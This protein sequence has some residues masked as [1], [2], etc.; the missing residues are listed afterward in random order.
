MVRDT[1]MTLGIL[2]FGRRLMSVLAL[3]AVAACAGPSWDGKVYHG[4]SV[5]F[6]VGRV[7]PG[8]RKLEDDASLLTFR[9]AARDLV[10]SVNGRC[11]KDGDDVPLKALTQHLFIYFT[12]R[13]ITD[14]RRTNLD[15]REALR[16]ELSAKLDGVARRFL[17][18]VLKKNSC[19]YDFIL[20]A[21]PPL[22]T[23]S[24]AEFDQFVG[25]FSTG[26]SQQGDRQSVQVQP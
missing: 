22:D 21:A 14:Q 15:G 25:G 13:Q 1:L 12:E 11:G 23:D 3:L 18:Y 16:T 20:I 10:V 8:W 9:D 6:R 19:V 24:K 2:S 17:V 5:S 26:Q 4:E 7:P